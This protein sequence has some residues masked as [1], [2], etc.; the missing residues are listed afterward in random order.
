MPRICRSARLREDLINERAHREAA[1]A[2]AADE[3]RRRVALEQQLERKDDRERRQ[4]LGLPETLLSSF[5]LAGLLLYGV[6]V[7]GYRAFYGTFGV[8]PEEAGLTY[9]QIVAQ[10]ALGA[11]VVI[12]AIVLLLAWRYSLASRLRTWEGQFLVLYVLSV[13]IIVALSF[14]GGI[15]VT[16][17]C[18]ALLFCISIPVGYWTWRRKGGKV[19]IGLIVLLSLV[20]L[21]GAPIAIGTE[22]ANEIKRDQL[23]TPMS[24]W[25]LLRVRV[26]LVDVKWSGKERPDWADPSVHCYYYLGE[27]NGVILLYDSQNRA[28]H[29]LSL[30]G[31]IGVTLSTCA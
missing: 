21:V 13:T 8:D 2:C 28:T 9:S 23:E 30:E 12:F 22:V 10:A 16:V 26:R 4:P 3:H 25:G 6:A 20:S 11:T 19:L 5:T 1:E 14:N 31:A 27:E 29:R 7:F 15:R 17:L 24:L 18:I